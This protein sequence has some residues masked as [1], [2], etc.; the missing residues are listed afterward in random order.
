M[1]GNFLVTLKLFLNAKSSL[2]LWSKLT[3]RHGKW[4]LNTN[5]FLIKTFLITTFDCIRTNELNNI[6]RVALLPQES[7]TEL[8]HQIPNYEHNEGKIFAKSHM[9][10]DFIEALIT[11]S[12]DLSIGSTKTK[13]LKLNTKT[14][15]LLKITFDF[16]IHFKKKTF[17]S[18]CFLV[19]PVK[20][21][22]KFIKFPFKRQ[23]VF[24]VLVFSFMYLVLVNAMD[25]SNNTEI[26]QVVHISNLASPV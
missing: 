22:K 7:L 13:Y 5:L 2:F 6:E 16:V 15:I 26:V 10:C 3:I 9:N 20:V 25:R 18:F 19:A 14:Q 11:E 24:W 17:F 8:F 4:F 21:Y 12:Y 1:I 23:K